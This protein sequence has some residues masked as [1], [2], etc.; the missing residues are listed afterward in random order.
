LKGLNVRP[1]S[2]VMKFEGQDSVAAGRSLGVDAVLEGSVHRTNN[3]VRV[4]A[5]LVR[6]GDRA[7]VWGAQF[8]EKAEDLLAVQDAISSQLA[9]ALAL[10]LT[11]GERKLL[12]RRYTESSD[13]FQLYLKGRYHWNKRS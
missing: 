5:R 3:R 10:N 8:D 13:A 2:A 9:T 11:N 12:T 7:P 1:T 4:T 6:V